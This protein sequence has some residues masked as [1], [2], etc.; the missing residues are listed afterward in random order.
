MDPYAGCTGPSGGASDIRLRKLWAKEWISTWSLLGGSGTPEPRLRYLELFLGCIWVQ[1]RSVGVNRMELYLSDKR[2]LA[3]VLCQSGVRGCLKSGRIEFDQ[4]DGLRIYDSF[5]ILN[6][7]ISGARTRSWR[8]FINGVSA[9]EWSHVMPED[10]Q[11]LAKE[12]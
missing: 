10:A 3:Y 2:V 8:V 12:P 9:P 7:Y 4:S 5:G 6:E 11:R 1:A